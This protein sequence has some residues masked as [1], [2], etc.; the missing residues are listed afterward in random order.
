MV[1]RAYEKLPAL[2]QPT[3][4]TD[5]QTW[6]V[7]FSGFTQKNHQLSGMQR[8]WKKLD[9]FR[10]PGV[11]IC[12]REWDARYER[13]AERIT[14]LTQD[15]YH[16]PM[17]IVAGYS[18]GGETAI[19]FCDELGKRGLDVRQLILC[20]AVRRWLARVPTPTSLLPWWRLTVPRNVDQ[21]DWFRQHRNQPRG[22]DVVAA[23]PEV[24]EVCGELVLDRIHE[25]CDDAPAFHQAVINAVSRVL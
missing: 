23:D 12:L 22:H 16:T 4:K 17:I 15:D 20:D 21:V 7:L 18:Y 9:R 19:R 6:I 13:L 11:R 1:P 5:R 2:A 14:L 3:D 10:A 24:T 25:Y 8:L